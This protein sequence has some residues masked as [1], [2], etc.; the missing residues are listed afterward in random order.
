MKKI[1]FRTLAVFVCLLLILV[2]AGIS[3]FK[4]A[5]GKIASRLRPPR[6]VPLSQR[7]EDLSFY[8]LDGQPDH[9]LA[10]RGKVV[11]LDLWGTWCL[12]CV[13]EMPTVQRLYDHYRND[14]QVEFLI[15]S[16]LD[17]PASVRRYARRNRLDLPFYVTR[18]E[19]IPNSMSLNQYPA[20]FLYAKDGSLVA[21]HTGAAD[22]SAPSVIAFIDALKNRTP[23]HRRKARSS[24][25]Y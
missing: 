3:F 12:Q 13:A 8:T 22:W 19:D 20:T 4:V 9:R 5:E 18:D 17:S 10:T 1:W 23:P 11:F 15:V 2:I 24:P 14:P 25:I 7:G 16:R 6:L 21:Q